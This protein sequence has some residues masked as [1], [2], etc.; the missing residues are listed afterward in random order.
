MCM[1]VCVSGIGV[2]L[3]VPHNVASAVPMEAARDVWLV[4]VAAVGSQED[5]PMLIQDVRA[6]A[7]ALQ[8]YGPLTGTG[9]Q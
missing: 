4:E 7:D 1:C 9:N 6:C 2:Q 8:G 5:V 3:D